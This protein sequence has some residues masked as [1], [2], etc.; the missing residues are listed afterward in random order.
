MP[1]F[2]NIILEDKEGVAVLTLNNPE[3]RNALTEE[4]KDEILS[5]LGEVDG[6]EELRALII[7]ARGPAFCAG[8][9]I[10]KIGGRLQPEE[11]RGVMIKSQDLLKRLIDLE[12]PVVTAVNGD[13]F[14]MGFNLVLVSDFAVASDRSRFCEV[15][16]KIGALPDFGALYFLPRII[17]PLKTRELVYFGGVIGAEE[18]KNMGLL[19]NVVPHDELEKES[20]ALA[21]RLARMPTKAIGRSKRLLKQAFDMTLDE[22]LSEE[23]EAQISLSQTEDH[24]E[25]LRAFLEKRKPVFKGR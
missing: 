2:K 7:T 23:I 3:T 21:G 25:G 15:F 19:Y 17:G 16:V 9:D 24:E 4:M 22:V 5:A 8:G 11:I 14:G 10:K 12:K 1:A 13:A 6:A 20:D 18:A